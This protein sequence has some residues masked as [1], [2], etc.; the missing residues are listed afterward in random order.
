[1]LWIVTY[2]L[3]KVMRPLYCDLSLVS[4]DAPII[5]VNFH[6]QEEAKAR[7]L[8]PNVTIPVK[9]KVLL[10]GSG[11]TVAPCVEYL[12]KDKSVAVTIGG[13]CLLIVRYDK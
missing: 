7:A 13:S 2:P 5:M 10:L 4:I 9:Q 3:N 12:T 1:M 8:G 6:S 11:F